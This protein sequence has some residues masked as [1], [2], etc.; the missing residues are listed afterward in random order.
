MRAG[1]LAITGL[2]WTLVVTAVS[3]ESGEDRRAGE[4]PMPQRTIAEVLKDVTDRV[5]SM[6]GV[7]GTAEGRCEG[8]PCVKVFVAKKTPELLRQIPRV[9]DGYPV[10]VEETDEFRA[11]DR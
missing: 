9:V 1:T 3:V 7:V 5:L 4:R 2:L 8:R 11:L 10:A 6:P